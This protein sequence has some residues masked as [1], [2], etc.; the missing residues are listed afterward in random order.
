MEINEKL[1]ERDM[2]TVK[3]AATYTGLSKSHI[4]KLTGL[5]RI[6]VYRP[7]GRKCFFDKSELNKWMHSNRE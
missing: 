6:P 4:Y 1:S 2:M 5:N 3:E 7:T